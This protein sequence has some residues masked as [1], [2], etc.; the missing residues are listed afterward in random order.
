M[1]GCRLL[2]IAGWMRNAGTA[3]RLI[4]IPT[5]AALLS[6]F[7]LSFC[8]FLLINEVKSINERT[9][10]LLLGVIQDL[11]R[12]PWAWATWLMRRRL[13]KIWFWWTL[14]EKSEASV[15]DRLLLYLLRILISLWGV[16]NYMLAALR[17]AN[18]LANLVGVCNVGDSY[19]ADA[20]PIGTLATSIALPGLSL[21]R[22]RPSIICGLVRLD[23]GLLC[24]RIVGLLIH[25]I[26]HQHE[27]R[28]IL[29]IVVV[30]A[31]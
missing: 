24:V 19:L 23:R 6:S 27:K 20:V 22:G 2:P 21:P 13:L 26:H 7:S 29:V 18:L 15:V 9:S 4:M 30:A 25:S 17:S 1:S 28:V 16:I 31:T 10:R 5:A 8:H 11:I 3:T 12:W 14:R